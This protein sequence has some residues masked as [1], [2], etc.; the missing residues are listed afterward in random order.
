M[1]T[2]FILYKIKENVKTI[3]ILQTRKEKLN[4]KK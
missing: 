3:A 1:N 4:K 2:S